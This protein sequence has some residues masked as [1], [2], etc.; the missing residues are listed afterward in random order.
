MSS[1]GSALGARLVERVEAEDVGS[2][3][4]APCTSPMQRLRRALRGGDTAKYLP[5][6]TIY[7][8]QQILQ[9]QILPL[10]FF[11]HA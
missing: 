3:E 7:L 2:D 4:L 6:Q 1:R 9:R 8:S 10:M 5:T 11:C